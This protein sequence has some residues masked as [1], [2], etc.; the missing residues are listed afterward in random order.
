[1]PQRSAH[2]HQRLQESAWKSESP[3]PA[4]QGLAHSG[5]MRS[6]WGLSVV[7]KKL[8]VFLKK[9]ACVRAK[10]GCELSMVAFLLV[11]RHDR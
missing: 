9:Y 5:V 2:Q 1:M 7:V 4:E 8:H 11:G 6:T 3:E 10:L